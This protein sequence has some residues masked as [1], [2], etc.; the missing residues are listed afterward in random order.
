MADGKTKSG[1]PTVEPTR[2]I[3]PRDAV[4]DAM[5]AADTAGVKKAGEVSRNG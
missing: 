2:V 4:P 5:K 3:V 1:P